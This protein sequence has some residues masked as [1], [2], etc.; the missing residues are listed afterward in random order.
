MIAKL[1]LYSYQDGST[2]FKMRLTD[3]GR[4]GYEAVEVPFTKKEWKYIPKKRINE[5]Q[6]VMPKNEK[7]FEIYKQNKEFVKALEVKY[8]DEIDKRI[9]LGKS[10][11]F[12]QIFQAVKNPKK[13][14]PQ[15]FY[16][17]F[18]DFIS[19]EKRRQA[20]GNA[21]NIQ[22]T[23]NKL[24]MNHK[25][26]LLFNE[27][28]RVFLMEFRESMENDNLS[29]NTI[30]IHLRNI[31]TVF[32]YAIKKLQV[33][34]LA[35]YPFI[36]GDIQGGLKTAYKSRALTL[37]EVNSIRDYRLKQEVNSDKWHACNY[38]IFGYAGRGINFIDIARLEWD[39]YKAGRIY[40]TRRKTRSKISEET[41]FPV[42]R[43]LKEI[44]QWYRKHNRQLGNPYIF[45]VLNGNHKTE[46]SKRN[47]IEKA[48]TE[49]NKLLRE[50]GEELKTSVPITTYVW[51][52]SFAGVAKNDLKVD[53]SMISEML[54]HHDL[55]TTQ[56]YLKQFPDDDK[57]NAVIGL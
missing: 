33:A 24:K 5:L 8:Q 22:G 36:D 57:D 38:F 9:R 37:T 15:T 17:V 23:L 40:F 42:T 29:K 56:H 47:R 55:E 45:P 20:F 2:S 31:R 43:E 21:A 41:N 3:K 50:I 46:N 19:K 27:V 7:K 25:A 12:S 35:D 53:V 51:R 13:E 34:S 48:R 52:H 28:D 32:N 11:S 1:I 10:F 26:D 16:S 54:G 30:S 39:N 49:L 18:D 6:A 14:K 4:R 44:L